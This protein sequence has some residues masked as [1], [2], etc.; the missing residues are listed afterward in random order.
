MRKSSMASPRSTSAQ[1]TGVETVARGC[2]PHRVDGGQRAAPGVLV[3]VDQH[4]AGRPLR[5]PVLG[6]HQ[7][8]LGGGQRLG[9]RL[10]HRPHLLLGRARARWARRRG[11]RASRWSWRS[12]ACPGRRGPRAGTGPSRA[13]VEGGALDG[14]E[15]EVQVVRAVGVV[16]ARVPGVEVDAAEVHHPEQRERHPGST[17]KSITLP[18]A[19]SIA[20][21]SI[22]SGRGAGARFMKKNGPAAPSG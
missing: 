2:G 21:V 12:S 22:H 6:G 4:A 1:V 13:P 8:G 5:D 20:Q 14:V 17:G 10:G 15:I 11:R 7:V 19:C 9:E 16:A 18:D 3:V